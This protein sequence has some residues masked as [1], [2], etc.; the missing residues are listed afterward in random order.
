[1]KIDLNADPILMLSQRFYTIRNGIIKKKK[2]K[3]G[4]KEKKKKV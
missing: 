4:K 3:K 2:E 1:V